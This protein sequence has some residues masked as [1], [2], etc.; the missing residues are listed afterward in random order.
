MTKR[1]QRS[2]T[3]RS[4]LR[5]AAVI[6]FVAVPVAASAQTPNRDLVLELRIAGMHRDVGFTHISAVLPLADGSTFVVEPRDHRVR[7]FSAAGVPAQ[8]LGRNGA[9]P[10]E[11]RNIARAG[12]LGDSLW[13]ADAG[14][15]R[16]TWYSKRR[17]FSSVSR[18]DQV[19]GVPRGGQHEL[20]G[21]FQGGAPW[22]E[23]SAAPSQVG[24]ESAPRR[25]HRLDPHTFARGPLLAEV[26]V[27]HAIFRVQD[28]PT[29]HFGRQPF[30]DAPIV[31]A[32]GDRVYIVNRRP[33]Q[34]SSLASFCVV[35]VLASGDTSWTI[36]VP[37][38]P[39]PL[40]RQAKDSVV[41][42]IAAGLSRTAVSKSAVREALFLPEYRSPVS[43]AFVS[44][45][46]DIWIRREDDV[47]D[48]LYQ[49]VNSGGKLDLETTVD[50][51]IRLVG[52]RGSHVWAVTF[53]FDD[54]PTLERYR[55]A[56]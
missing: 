44:V 15:R 21:Y 10:G 5:A 24:D 7:W 53:D 46:G 13:V 49:R 45:E 52:A 43:E 37:Y 18:W 19:E 23:P 3:R 42:R 50:R 6:H 4:L 36:D 38:R 28:G 22:G 54:V 14:T 33:A 31:L 11:F 56:P 1:Q 27:N 17:A 32:S 12:L 25:I 26:A 55:I 8:T 51:S 40:P 47:G 2:S 39:R 16:T 29:M 34:S 48:V 30:A 41:D 20:L 35:A 9:G